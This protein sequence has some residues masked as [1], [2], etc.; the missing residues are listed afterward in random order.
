MITVTIPAPVSTQTG[1]PFSVARL[2]AAE[3][4]LIRQGDYLLARGHWRGA[5]VSYRY[6]LRC[7]AGWRAQEGR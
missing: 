5:L 7:E 1:S 2:V 4:R 6:A 3:L